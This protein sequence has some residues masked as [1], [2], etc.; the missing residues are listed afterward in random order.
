[1]IE[2]ETDQSIYDIGMKIAVDMENKDLMQSIGWLK[3]DQLLQKK[4]AQVVLQELISGL[5]DVLPKT[6]GVDFFDIISDR[7][8]S[9]IRDNLDADSIYQFLLLCGEHV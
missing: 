7:I 8:N 5:A 3:D 4:R 1:M 9:A 2:K 6:N